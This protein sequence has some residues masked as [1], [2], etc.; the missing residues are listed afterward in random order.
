MAMKSMTELWTPVLINGGIF[1]DNYLV[2]NLGR[3]KQKRYYSN[4]S[5]KFVL[6]HVINSNRP[7]VKMTANGKKYKKSLAKLVLS[8][9]HYR[10][11]CECANITYL[12]GDMK[13]CQLS[14]LR[15]RTDNSIYTT[16]ELDKEEELSKK[17]ADKP[18]NTSVSNTRSIRSIKKKSNAVKMCVTMCAKY[19][20]FAGIENMST[21]FA[22]VG[23]NGYKPREEAQ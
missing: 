20:C 13:N 21:D 8:S 9:F 23:C 14:N 2:S 7:L 5:Y 12:D 16:S 6:L 11:R 17:N 19:P 15:Y 18:K 3:V 10:D 4:G 22:A 1:K